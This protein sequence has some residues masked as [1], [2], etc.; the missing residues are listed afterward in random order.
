MFIRVTPFRSAT[1]VVS[2]MLRV[3]VFLTVPLLAADAQVSALAQKQIV[4]IQNAKKT[5]TAAERKL[6]SN[7]VFA[8]R[9]ARSEKVGIDT[10]LV[11]KGRFDI[12]SKARVI[13]KGNITPALLRQI[14]GSSGNVI[15]VSKSN[16]S[17]L[18]KIPVAALKNIAANADVQ[19]VSEDFGL[20]TNVGALT[21]QGY[22]SHQ[23]NLVI[24]NLGYNGAG[25]KVGVLSDSALPARVNALIT[26]GDLGANTV[27]L[28]GLAGPSNGTD[29]GAA[30]MEIIHDIAPGAQL[31]F[32]TAYD[33]EQK[34]ASNIG[35]L[36]AQGCSIIV[37]D[38]T[39][40][41][42]SAF[43]DGPIAQAVNTFAANGG[44]YFSSAG[45]SGNLT[46]GTS[47]TWEGDYLDGGAT[48]GALA[49]AGRY[50]N[51]G[52][53][54][55][56]SN[57]D[58]ITATTGYIFLKWS[59]PA[60][61]SSNDYDL[62]ILNSAGTNVVEAS[63]SFQTG[64]QDPVEAVNPSFPGER[65][66]V[67]KFAGAARALRV[68]TNRGGL[69]LAT[70]GATHGHNGGQSTLTVAATYWNSAR[71]G[72][73]PFN[74]T[75]NPVETFSSDGP[76]K[77]FYNPNG[78]PITPNNFLFGTNG[79]LTLQK[80]D[81]TAADGVST[82]TPGFLPFFGTSAAAPHAAG[83]AALI[84]SANPSLTGPQI[85]S[86]LLNTALNNGVP[87]PDRDGGAGV[88]V[89]LPAV[90]AALTTP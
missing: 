64:T 86:I 55:S 57:Y 51:F 11:N 58:T 49:G 13:V 10:K 65:I 80:P 28:P 1:V 50:H 15:S 84:K 31:Y 74:G 56:P 4:S 22:I 7:L 60:G 5:F 46:N 63:T 72:T 14:T 54:G 90:Q 34:F 8:G 18:A 44:L 77:I 33:T 59:D 9:Q 88:L 21:S 83:I 25:V 38:V 79:G 43:Q 23:A 26:S 29:E 76:R 89:A 35:A 27:V 53:S 70:A 66:V 45:N 41:A 61:A 20:T 48:S 30:M 87:G 85:K 52:T 73:K 36:A 62:Y 24:N 2:L 3:S 68:D 37:D 17:I 47:G 16:D 42:E 32:A 40:F 19:S 71:T 6:P 67:V 82:K 75:N 12:S 81:F 78:T 69:A 39:Y